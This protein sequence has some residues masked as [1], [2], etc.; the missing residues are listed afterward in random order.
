MGSLQEES[1]RG[2]NVWGQVWDGGNSELAKG[3]CVRRDDPHAAAASGDEDNLGQ[4]AD[5]A[6]L[7]RS[8]AERVQVGTGRGNSTRGRPSTFQ[9]SIRDMTFFVGLD[10]DCA[11][12]AVELTVLGE[13]IH[14]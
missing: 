6:K 12:P 14:H 7:D 8:G 10:F 4:A 3:N 11:V 9:A 1:Y 2:R 13:A 5:D